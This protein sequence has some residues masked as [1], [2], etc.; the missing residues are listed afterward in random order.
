MQKRH[1]IVGAVM[2]LASAASYSLAH[3]A[4]TIATFDVADSSTPAVGLATAPSGPL[5]TPNAQLIDHLGVLSDTSVFVVVGVTL[6]GIAAG[7]R[8]H[9]S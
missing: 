4:A 8:R 5:S 2:L 9:A 1:V 3:I 6:L 7:L